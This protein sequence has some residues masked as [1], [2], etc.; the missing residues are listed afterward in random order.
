MVGVVGHFPTPITLMS[1]LMATL[2]LTVDALKI[3]TPFDPY[4]PST[5][6]LPTQNHFLMFFGRWRF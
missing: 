1:I 5:P 6:T 2:K 3:K 4:H